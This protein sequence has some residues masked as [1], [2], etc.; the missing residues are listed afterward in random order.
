MFITSQDS[1]VQP[2]GIN[3][4]LNFGLGLEVAPKFKIKSVDAIPELPA[5][6]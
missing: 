4:K 6:I 3:I 1:S 2:S 5:N